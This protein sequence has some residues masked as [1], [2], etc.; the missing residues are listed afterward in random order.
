M[1]EAAY[2]RFALGGRRPRCRN[3]YSRRRKVATEN[4]TMITTQENRARQF[5]VGLDAYRNC[6]SWSLMS[7]PLP[8][9]RLS[10]MFRLHG[11]AARL[12]SETG[13]FHLSDAIGDDFRQ[14]NDRLV[15]RSEFHD[16][17]FD[18]TAVGHQLFPQAAQIAD[19]RINFAA[20]AC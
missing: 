5:I 11:G 14:F 13:R 3:R 20:G 19:Q 2:L 7:A 4:P 6:R 12:F 18:P 9:N 16:V 8:D 15:Q 17:V 10:T 1:R